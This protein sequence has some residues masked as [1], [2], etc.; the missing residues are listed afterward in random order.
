MSPYV[1]VCVCVVT[2]Q[3]MW[4]AAR[5]SGAAPTYFRA[6]GRFLDGG[7]MSN[8]PTLDVLTEIHQ[9]NLALQATVSLPAKHNIRFYP[10]VTTLRL[11]LCFRKS[12]CLSSVCCLSSACNVEGGWSFRQYFFTTV[13][14][15]HPLTSVHE[16]H[17]DRPRR[18]PPPGALNARGVSK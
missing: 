2:D 10:N 18:I 15:G 3:C 7:L 14:A 12:V 9:Y 13:Y 1:C 16:F 17:G 8:N 4:Q 11:G 6:F 5:S